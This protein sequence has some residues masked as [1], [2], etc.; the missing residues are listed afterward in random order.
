MSGVAVGVVT[1]VG[2]GVLESVALGAADAGVLAVACGVAI[3]ADVGAAGFPGASCTASGIVP[4]A[5]DG[6]GDAFAT[7]P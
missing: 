2:T 7:A 4:R 6:I 3:G 1:F 5:F